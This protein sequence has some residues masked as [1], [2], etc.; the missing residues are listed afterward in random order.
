MCCNL[1]IFLWMLVPVCTCYNV[2][3]HL[4]LVV[5]FDTTS[6]PPGLGMDPPSPMDAIEMED[7]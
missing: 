3:H 7:T 6:V 1:L 2:L 5:T 4:M